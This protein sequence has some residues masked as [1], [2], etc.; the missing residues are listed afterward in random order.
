MKKHLI[1]VLL[2]LIMILSLLT[3][4]TTASESSSQENA[5]TAISTLM[6]CVQNLTNMA[7]NP[8]TV[9]ALKELHDYAD[10]LY[11]VLELDPAGYIIFDASYG[12]ILEYSPS[13][14]SP[15]HGLEED[16][17]YLGATYYYSKQNE[18][19]LKDLISGEVIIVDDSFIHTAQDI[20]EQIHSSQANL[21]KSTIE[22]DSLDSN[23]LQSI[24]GTQ[25]FPNP[26]HTTLTVKYISG[27]EK[28]KNLKTRQQIGYIDGGLC[29]YIATGLLLYWIDECNLDEEVINDFA[30]LQKNGKGFWGNE[31]T[32]ELRSYG[33]YDATA[34]FDIPLS[35]EDICDVIDAYAEA[36]CLAINYDDDG[37]G[38]T[39]NS[40]IEWLKEK[41]RP[42]ILFGKLYD[43]QPN[44][45]K[46]NHAV[47]AYGWTSN[48]E[49]VAHYGWENYAEVVV[50]KDVSFFGS[51]VKFES[52][53]AY[54]V[55]IT[56]VTQSN[57]YKWAY[58]ATQYCGRYGVLTVKKQKFSP[59]D[60]VTRGELIQALY[61][62]TGRPSVTLTIFG[63]SNVL[64]PF[65][66]IS[67]FSPYYKAAAWA[68]EHK[69]LTGTSSSK[70]SLSKSLTRAQAAV[71]IMRYSQYLSLSY[72]SS[73]GPAAS[74]FSDYNLV[75]AWAKDGI[76]Y[77]T[78]RYILLGVG[79]N[80]LSPSG[81]LTRAE[82]AV[83]L[84]RISQRA[85][86]N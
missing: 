3:L 6:D 30:F 83:I 46:C 72:N 48:N 74:S 60:N 84:Y 52:S 79:G 73:S 53:T 63:T 55:P 86:R 65:T 19:E 27:G 69:I 37:I 35:T 49:I 18:S 13:S 56:D 22:S 5:L 11:Y 51:S 40:V 31:L 32:R 4:P 77:C 1:A 47:L 12:I 70:L 45:T 23:S 15:Y 36:H 44:G 75:P 43:P 24:V 82:I 41:D 57:S 21:V 28:L 62:L 26:T 81:A 58:A 59:A 78:R 17:F 64:K 7:N 68:V 61:T 71:F 33:D 80:T 9:V 25:F 38:H 34:A 10:N 8:R 54:A 29:G 66:D 42:V 67:K 20:S 50:Q 39:L 2:V 16:L 76:D 85:T 14:P